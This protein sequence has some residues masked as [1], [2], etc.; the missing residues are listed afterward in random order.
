VVRLFLRLGKR[1]LKNDVEIAAQHYKC[2][3]WPAAGPSALSARGVMHRI[4]V[5]GRLVKN[6]DAHADDGG[7]DS[8]DAGAPFGRGDANE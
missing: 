6:D 2:A 1:P 7:P 3:P 5:R 4:S 8:E